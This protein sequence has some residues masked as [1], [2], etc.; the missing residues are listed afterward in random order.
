MFDCPYTVEPHVYQQKGRYVV[1]FVNYL[2]REKAPGKSYFEKEAPIAAEP[3]NFQLQL[4]K[5]EK[6]TRVRFLDPDAEGET[7]PKFQSKNGRITV[8]TP[9]FLTYGVCIIEVE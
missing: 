9:K 4:M 7:A 3:I 2:H 8:T 6:A 1:H 5:G